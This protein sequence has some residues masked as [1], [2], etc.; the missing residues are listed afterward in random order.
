MFSILKKIGIYKWFYIA[1]M[2]Y[3]LPFIFLAIFIVD[4]FTFHKT[5]MWFW[6]AFLISLIPCGL[7]GLV[8]SIIGTVKAAKNNNVLNV[9]IGGAFIFAAVSACVG[10]VLGLMLIYVV[11]G[12]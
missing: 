11:V 8:L 10:G 2:C 12:G 6:L 5:D 4:Q 9:V 1:A 3:A 7:A